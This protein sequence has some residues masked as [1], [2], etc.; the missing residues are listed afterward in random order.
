LYG[1]PRWGIKFDS[2]GAGHAKLED[3]VA[4][5]IQFNHGGTENA[6][7]AMNKKSGSHE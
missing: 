1:A 4:T 2:E 3:G 6:E 5:I 7:N